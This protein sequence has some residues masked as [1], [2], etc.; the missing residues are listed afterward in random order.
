MNQTESNAAASADALITVVEQ[1]V[2]D[3][4]HGREAQVALDSSLE[5]DLGLDSLA[6]VELVLRI[7]RAFDVSLPEHALY[8]AET[9]RDLLRLI[10]GS[11][12]V[13]R[14]EPEKRVRSLV[15]AEPGA[16]ACAAETLLDALA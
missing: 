2:R 5:R 10:H 7:E 15:Q 11:A 13:R 8:A 1:M 4:R 3:T 16:A 6:R 9:P 12:G 14:A